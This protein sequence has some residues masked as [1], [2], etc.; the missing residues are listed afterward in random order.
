LNVAS[1]STRASRLLGAFREKPVRRSRAELQALRALVRSPVLAR[2]DDNTFAGPRQPGPLCEALAEAG[3]RYFTE[4]DWR[5]G[6]RPE[7]L[8]GLAASG[9]VQVLVG[10]ESL[11]FRHPG[12]GPKQAELERVMD[13]VRAIQEAGVAVLGCFL[14]GCDGETR[15][16]LDRL[17]AFLLESPLADIQLTLQT[18]FPGTA[19]RPGRTGREGRPDAR[20]GDDPVRP[21]P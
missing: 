14:V 18:P 13:A 21:P 16:S 12:M 15:Q 9:C 3:V 5:I 6:E 17:T 19:A 1:P 20:G 10:L 8:A 7:V 11:V 4:V 2:A